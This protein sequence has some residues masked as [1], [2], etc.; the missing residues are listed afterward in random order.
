MIY[1]HYIVWNN[2]THLHILFYKIYCPILVCSVIPFS[3]QPSYTGLLL[4][5]NNKN[6]IKQG[7]M[8][9]AW[10]CSFDEDV[11]NQSVLTNKTIPAG[12]QHLNRVLLIDVV[13]IDKSSLFKCFY[14][15]PLFIL[16]S[17]YLQSVCTWHL[18][19]HEHDLLTIIDYNWQLCLNAIKL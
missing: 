3:R 1:Y 4:D 6:K 16:I 13:I 8:I 17:K 7:I 14:N 12:N 2:P 10:S 15:I 9:R 11:V 5:I 18:L 19:Q